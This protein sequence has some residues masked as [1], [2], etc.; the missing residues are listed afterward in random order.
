MNIETNQN[1]EPVYDLLYSNVKDKNEKLSAE[2]T[3]TLISNISKLDRLGIDLVYVLIRIHSLRH[4]KA[5]ILEIPYEGEQLNKKNI[6]EDLICDIKFSI[7]K[8]PAILS[9]ILLQ[10][11]NLHIRRLVEEQSKNVNI[12]LISS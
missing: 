8:L 4:S 6:E 9:Q 5:K 7:K 10:F 12:P 11:T 2:D 1:F 3:K